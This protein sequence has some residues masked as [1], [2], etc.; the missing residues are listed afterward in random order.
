MALQ[1]KLNETP[2]SYKLTKHEQAYVTQHLN[3]VMDAQAIYL[4]LLK[5]AEEAAVFIRDNNGIPANYVLSVDM[6]EFIE[7]PTQAPELGSTTVH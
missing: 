7:M 5:S 3:K 6:S 1:D 2:K 4:G